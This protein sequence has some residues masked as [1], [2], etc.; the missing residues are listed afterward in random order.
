MINRAAIIWALLILLINIV[1]II[2]VKL[3]FYGKF[4]IVAIDILQLALL[5]YYFLRLMWLLRAL[6]HFEF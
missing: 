4:S 3:V 6:H 5:S 2:D 1:N